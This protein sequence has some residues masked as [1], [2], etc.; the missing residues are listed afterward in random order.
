MAAQDL[1]ALKSYLRDYVERIT[2]RSKS[3]LY[4]CPICGSGTHAHKDGAFSIFSNGERCKC[5]SCGFGEGRGNGADIFDL[6]AAVEKK[7][8]PEATKTIID[9]YGSAGNSDISNAIKKGDSMES[10]NK[11]R[12]Y[13][14]YIKRCAEALPGS[15]AEKYLYDRGFTDEIIAR[16]CLGYD[17]ECYNKQLRKSVESIVI[18]YSGSFTYYATRAIAEKAYDKPRTIE[19]GREPLFNGAALYAADNVFVTESQLCAISIIQAGGAAVAIGGKGCT[20]LYEQLKRKP[21]AATLILCLDA[22]EPGRK[23]TEDIDEMLESLGV[24]HVDGS[25][26]IMGD[27]EPGSAD[28]CKDPNEFLQRNGTAA[29]AE[30][31]RDAIAQTALIRDA[32]AQEAEAERQKRTGAGM[33]DSFLEAIQSER[34]KPLPTGITDIDRALTGGLFR[35]TLVVLG[36]APGAGKTALCQW[37]LEGMAKRGTPCVYLNLEMSREQILA[38]SFSRLAAR[39]GF[40]INA[41]TV[42]KGY[43][44]TEEQ[45]AAIMAAAAEYKESIANNMI[46]N[47][48]GVTANL[49]GILEYCE[50]E[51]Q[52]AESA[53]MAAPIVCLDY[54]QLLCGNPGEDS[55]TVIKRAVA[56][57]KAFAIK[58]STVVIVIIAHNRASNSSGAVSMESGRDTSAIEYSADLQL[59]LAFTECIKKP[60]SKTK[61]KTPEELTPEE[62]KRVT[63]RVVKGRFGGAGT[64]VDLHFSGETMSYTQTA[65]EFTEYKGATPF[66]KADKPQQTIIAEF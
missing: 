38:R 31:V 33:V 11:R 22:D 17:R 25:G 6:C 47:P 62:R 18:P 27:A 46:Y 19:A 29:L 56:G 40:R 41:N 12:D 66:D 3:G 34:F 55:A 43:Q 51:A 53:G 16:F 49:D 30:A 42:L 5:F 26:V 1:N 44:W 23:A 8:L 57:F 24:F 14:D 37:I 63:L 28:Y 9:L 20:R 7:T 54:L 61:P 64:D 52:R 4:V 58:H 45:R 21:T 13:S 65:P 10:G 50:Q 32:A 60:G 35:E 59:A 36:A 15:P 39:Q 48:D 2:T